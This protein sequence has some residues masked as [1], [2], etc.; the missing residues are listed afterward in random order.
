MR[1]RWFWLLALGALA[2]L[3]ILPGVAPAKSKAADT[4]FVNGLVYTVD[5]SGTTAQAVAVRDGKIIFVGPNNKTKR[6]IGTVTEVVDLAGKMLLP[7]FGDA[8]AHINMTVSFLY[9][10][11]LYG[12]ADVAAYQQAIADFDVA[13]P[14]TDVIRGGGWSEAK[15]PGIGPLKEDIDAVVSDRPVVIRSDGYHSV[16]VNS[17]AL[18][19]AGIDGNTPNPED[20]VIERVPGTVGS[21]RDALRRA[22]GLPARDRRGPHGRDRRRL[23]RPAV[24]GRPALLPAVLR[25]AARLHAH[26]RPAAHPGLERHPGLRRTGL[27]R[28][29]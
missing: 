29:S 18:A 28:A 17:F 13:N 24:Q 6:C 19:L 5:L 22:V 12:L 4:V 26:P 7:A 20:G 15:F 27:R 25:R 8:H 1:H 2:V 10:V 16:W 21:A 9:S 3:L 11:N 23:H 14:G